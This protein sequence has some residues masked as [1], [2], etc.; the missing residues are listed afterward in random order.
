MTTLHSHET[1]A[2]TRPSEVHAAARGGSL[3]DEF[4]VQI[5]RE[6]LLTNGRGGF[7]SGTAAGVPTRRYHG[8]LVAAARPPLER[9]MLLSQVL[10]KVRV[11]DQEEELATFEF[12]RALHP[13][14]FEMQTSFHVRNRRPLPWMQVTFARDAVRLTKLVVFPRG[15][16]EVRIH[17]RLEGPAGS[18]V[19]LEICPFTAMRDFHHLR[20]AFD[21]GFATSPG[22]DHVAVDAPE[23]GPRVWIRAQR[24]DGG[25]VRFDPQGGWWYG[26]HYREE[27]HRGQD[28]YEDLY[29]PGW[30]RT[31]GT[32]CLELV[33]RAVADFS[34]PQERRQRPALLVDGPPAP[35][36]VVSAEPPV[37]E[38]LADAADAFVVTRRLADGTDSV[39]VIAGYHWFGDWGRDTFIAL[40]GLLL[41]TG[42]FAEA[43]EVLRTFALAQ[44]E[45][46]IPNRFCDWG[47]GCDYNSVDASLWFMRAAEQYCEMSGDEDAWTEFLRPSC[48]RIVESFSRGTLFRICVARDGLIG[49]G[50]ACTQ[51]TWMDAKCGD[52]VFTPRHGKP[53][54]VN[55]LWY[56]CLCMMAERAAPTDAGAAA[57]YREMAARVASAFVPTFWNDA[58]RCLYD[59]VNDR[60]RDRAVRPN[61]IFAV[62]LP[63]SPL[64]EVQQRAVLSCVECELLTPYGLRSLSPRE[65]GYRRHYEGDGFQR[66]S[67][68]HQGTVWGWLIG[69][70]VE[71]YLRVHDFSETARKRMRARLVPL[72]R[73]L[74]SAG[75]GSISEIF[76]ADPPHTP[77]GCIAQAWSVAELLRAWRM[78]AP[79]T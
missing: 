54:E 6:W 53:V 18:P 17:Y 43:R 74:D 15:V 61:Q 67:A 60:W 11:A 31:S 75:I 16:D 62:S 76:D 59:V 37:E 66:D 10:E 72:V 4:E 69:P 19:S 71:A 29:V 55:A 56:H 22:S 65:P 49:C 5:Q 77:R 34:P 48:E 33:V 20:R 57:R 28:C 78:S 14:G 41:E 51:L 30:F 13:R 9:W 64:D 42:R 8:L 68:Y 40:P 70:Y 45:G 52:V 32:G 73:H 44:H 1:P 47:T 24:P 7:A 27:A 79:A 2:R 26:F 58:Q 63:H 12:H 3:L 38:R 46:L 21:G 39:S 25:E 50:D 35:P 36:E 23:G